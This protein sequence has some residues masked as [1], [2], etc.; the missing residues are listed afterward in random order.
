[1][2]SANTTKARRAALMC[3]A[4]IRTDSL[5]LL[6]ATQAPLRSRFPKDSK[7]WIPS[8]NRG[9]RADIWVV[10]DDIRW[11]ACRDPPTGTARMRNTAQRRQVTL[12]Y[13]RS[14]GTK[15]GKLSRGFQDCLQIGSFEKSG[16]RAALGTPARTERR[17]ARPSRHAKHYRGHERGAGDGGSNATAGPRQGRS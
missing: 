9:A 1:M 17:R 11:R 5:A 10:P 3:P 15:A 2:G 16:V 7:S 8:T 6:D 14:L 13:V 4:A 12:P